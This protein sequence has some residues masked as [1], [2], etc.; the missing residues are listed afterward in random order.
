[1]F[2]KKKLFF[3]QTTISP[4]NGF[5]NKTKISANKKFCKKIA[6]PKK[7]SKI[8]SHRKNISAKKIVTKLKTS[9]CDYSKTHFPIN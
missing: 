6:L 4:K 5:T 2:I 7:K 1:M 9:N 8:F 3:N